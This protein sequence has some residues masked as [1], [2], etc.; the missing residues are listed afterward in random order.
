MDSARRTVGS[1][2]GVDEE[3]LDSPQ[4]DK[5]VVARLAGIVAGATLPA[6][7]TQ[8]LAVGARTKSDFQDDLAELLGEAHRGVDEARLLFELVQDS[9]QLHPVLL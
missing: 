5:L 9:L 2:P 4:G 1:A 8:G 7:G 6:A 3:D